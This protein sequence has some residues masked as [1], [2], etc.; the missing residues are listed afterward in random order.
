MV[1]KEKLRDT[2]A[3]A[4]EKKDRGVFTK[5]QAHAY[6]MGAFYLAMEVTD[7]IDEIIEL[8]F[9]FEKGIDLLQ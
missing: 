5:S 2:C 4:I 8:R 7:G 3:E 9:I 6:M 1:L